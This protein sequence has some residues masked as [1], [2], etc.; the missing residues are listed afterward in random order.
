MASGKNARL[1]A[2]AHGQADEILK[3]EEEK[4]AEIIRLNKIIDSEETQPHDVEAAQMALM[5]LKGSFAKS[6]AEEMAIAAEGITQK[7]LEEGQ[8]QLENLA[9]QVSARIALMD[10]VG[11]GNKSLIKEKQ[12]EIATAKLMSEG[13]EQEIATKHRLLIQLNNQLQVLKDLG[14]EKDRLAELSEI[15]SE[16]TKQMV[17]EHQAG[18]IA[19][20][21][22]EKYNKA[23]AE[24]KEIT[25]AV[26]EAQGKAIKPAE[27]LEDAIKELGDEILATAK[28]FE[29]ALSEEAEAMEAL[30][31]AVTDISMQT[32][33]VL[34]DLH[35][36]KLEKQK[37]EIEKQYEWESE[38]LQQQLDNKLLT[39]EQYDR[40]QLGLKQQFLHEQLAIEKKQAAL[41]KASRISEIMVDLAATI[42][43]ITFKIAKTSGAGAAIW[44]ASLGVAIAASAIAIASI[45]AEPLPGLKK[46]TKS[47]KE[48]MYEVGEA[49]PEIMYV[50]EGAQVMSNQKRKVWDAIMNDRLDA[51]TLNDHITRTGQ[52]TQPGARELSGRRD[53]S[54]YKLRMAIKGNKSV[55]IENAYS[56]AGLI[57]NSVGQQFKFQKWYN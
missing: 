30:Q 34:F 3:L 7:E 24:Q 2:L 41:N 36:E 27:D 51:L 1:L 18:G 12:K 50:P 48:G 39:Q 11:E 17:K 15:M 53:H 37:E 6:A 43:D 23:K 20:D 16:I 56:L 28:G 25:E 47:A 52:S 33:D 26:A 13:T 57:G 4:A 19:T 44:G 9:A 14:K 21:T 10:K 29:K 31:Q 32:A 42:A 38:M 40:E 8:K 35:Q 22:I 54:D 49:G 5:T 45:V 55:N 46:G